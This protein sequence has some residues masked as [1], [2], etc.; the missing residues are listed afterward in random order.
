[1]NPRREQPTTL[2]APG[3]VRVVDVVG[4]M[5]ILTFAGWIL[6]VG[7]WTGRDPRPMAGLVILCGVTA[8][9]CRSV[10][11][12]WVTLV[13]GTFLIVLMGAIVVTWPQAIHPTFGLTGYSNANG[14][15]YV[16]GV[17]M[18]GLL[19]MRARSP[20]ARIAAVIAAIVLV[21]LPWLFSAD[22]AS[23]S[24][25]VVVAVT[26]WLFVARDQALP[27]V[28]LHSMLLVALVILATGLAGVFYSG[29]GRGDGG[30]RLTE[31]RLVL[32]SESAEML[33][34]QPLTGVGPGGF[35][36]LNPTA[37]RDP[38]ARWAHHTPL[39]VGAE[40]GLPGLLLFLGILVW[41]F[42]WLERGSGRRGGALA[43]LV[44][45]L[46]AVHASI[47]FVWH[48]PAVPLALAALIGAG[49]SAGRSP[50][51]AG[52]TGAR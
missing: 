33:A 7:T 48:V 16:V 49:A 31:R 37:L 25:V 23:A 10:T 29:D 34:A 38:D 2:S 3:G 11:R 36:E 43:S 13:P 21:T 28:L 15:L 8:F 51:A 12:R 9:V 17:G 6:L 20:A 42:V 32:W 18:A 47:D 30:W 19:V 35:A 46:S 24:V 40:T 26:G 50:P 14:A 44:L 52:R 39:Q 45:A 41:A 27:S 5:L 4:V 1:M 22:T